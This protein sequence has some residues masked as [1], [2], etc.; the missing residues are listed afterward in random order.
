[1]RRSRQLVEAGG[2]VFGDYHQPHH[3]R[4]AW[5]KLA[6]EYVLRWAPVGTHDWRKFVRP[7]ELRSALGGHGLVIRDLAG[8]RFRLL[9]NSFEISGDVSINYGCLASHREKEAD[10]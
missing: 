10:L 7:D 4:L 9:T 5:G 8:L 2:G 1:M 3:A 6:A